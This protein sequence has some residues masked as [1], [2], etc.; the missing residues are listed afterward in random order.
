[1]ER[2]YCSTGVRLA[3]LPKWIEYEGMQHWDESTEKEKKKEGRS[4][5]EVIESLG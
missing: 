5:Q 3:Y 4:A 2:D 1:M